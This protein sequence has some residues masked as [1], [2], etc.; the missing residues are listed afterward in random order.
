MQ[1]GA[2]NG[3]GVYQ[4]RE[5]KERKRERETGAGREWQLLQLVD[6][7]GARRAMWNYFGFKTMSAVKPLTA[8]HH[9]ANGVTKLDKTVEGQT[10]RPA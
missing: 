1:R 3:A 8:K 10:P 5:I 9:C 2:A 4:Q 7:P 6:K